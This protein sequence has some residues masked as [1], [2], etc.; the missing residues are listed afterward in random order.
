MVYL[1]MIAVAALRFGRGPAI[2]AAALSVALYDVF[3]LVPY[4]TFAVAEAQHIFTFIMMFAIGLVISEL[5]LR[6]RREEQRARSR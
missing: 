4:F 2:A 6:A 3:F 1:L 5:T